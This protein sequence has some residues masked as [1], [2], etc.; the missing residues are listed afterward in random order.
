MD[1][2]G[3]L[4]R[5]QF[6]EPE[7]ILMEK[8]GEL[9][10]TPKITRCDPENLTHMPCH[11]ALVRETSCLRNLGNGQAALKQQ[12]SSKFNPAL[13]NVPMKRHTHGMPKERP[14]M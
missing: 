5:A 8:L 14:G 2:V 3:A 11:V 7:H 1:K 13:N 9:S 12:G 6:D 10:G 4:F